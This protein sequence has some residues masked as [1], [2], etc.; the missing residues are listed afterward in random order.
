[1]TLIETF[2]LAFSAVGFVWIFVATWVLVRLVIA[3]KRLREEADDDDDGE[4]LIPVWFEPLLALMVKIEDRL[5]D[6]PAKVEAPVPMIRIRYSNARLTAA[7]AA[8]PLLPVPGMAKNRSARFR[9]VEPTQIAG[10][11]ADLPVSFL[12]GRDHTT[13]DPGVSL[14]L[15]E[16][17]KIMP[18]VEIEAYFRAP[19]DQA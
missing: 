5:G 12:I 7:V 3:H 8:L 1:V 15:A 13:Y 9:A 4:P 18:G 14:T 6:A 10:F 16:P 19:S 11:D 2:A 17:V